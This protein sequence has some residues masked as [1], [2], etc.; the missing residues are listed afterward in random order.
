VI[1]RH[2]RIKKPNQLSRGTKDQ[3]YLS[4]RFGLIQ[5]LESYGERLPVIVDEAL[6]NCDPDRARVAVEAFAELARTNQ[7]LVMTCHPW[8]RD[9][10]EEVSPNTKVI[11]L[12]S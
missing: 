10:F 6:V 9:L 3:L 4:L 7:V 8:M 5:S 1:D 12:D 11:E 2:E